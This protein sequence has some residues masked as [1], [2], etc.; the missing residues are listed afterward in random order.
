MTFYQ[1][2]TPQPIQPLHKQWYNKLADTLL[3]DGESPVSATASQYA[4]ICEKYFNHNGLVKE[5][6]WEH[7]HKC[8]FSLVISFC[9]FPTGFL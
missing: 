8:F 3:G 6:T 9:F 5:S 2:G 4:L 7:A 1:I